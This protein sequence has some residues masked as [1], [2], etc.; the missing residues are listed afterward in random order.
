MFVTKLARDNLRVQLQLYNF[1]FC[2][3][4]PIVGHVRHSQVNYVHSNVFFLSCL[5]HPPSFCLL[6]NAFS[7]FGSVGRERKKKT[8]LEKEPEIRRPGTSA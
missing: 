7:D 4:I 3:W 2:N 1:N 8:K 5:G 6:S